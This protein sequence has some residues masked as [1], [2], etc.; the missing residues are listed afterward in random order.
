MTASHLP[1]PSGQAPT[2]VGA[3][4]AHHIT[5]GVAQ[6][7]KCTRE[8][9]DGSV[10]AAA[11]S[12]E[13]AAGVS[14]G[15]LI[16]FCARCVAL[17]IPE[18]TKLRAIADDHTALLAVFAEH[19]LVAPVEVVNSVNEYGTIIEGGVNIDIPDDD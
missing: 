16:E 2:K 1:R 11:R 17:G 14:L 6:L 10:G 7:R 9:D 18:T 3:L 5:P 8:R 4:S 19:Q 13:N 15:D 12:V